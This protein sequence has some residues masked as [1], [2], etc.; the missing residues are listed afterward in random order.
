MTKT[1]KENYN[2]EFFN[3]NELHTRICTVI[4]NNED[5][6]ILS[7]R[8][9]EGQII[10][11]PGIKYFPKDCQMEK[12][13][14]FEMKISDFNGE[15]LNPDTKIKIFK[16]KVLHEDVE[17]CE[18]FYK[19]IS[20]TNFD[21][22]S[23]KYK[24]YKDM[25]RFKKE[26]KLKSEECLKIKIMNSDIKIHDVK[27]NLGMY[28]VNDILTKNSIKN[29]FSVNEYDNLIKHLISNKYKRTQMCLDETSEVVTL[30]SLHEKCTGDVVSIKCPSRHLITLLGKNNLSVNDDINLSIKIRIFLADNNNEEISSDTR[31]GIIK[32][33]VDGGVVNIDNILYKD[34]SITAFQK[35]LPHKIKSDKEWYSLNEGLYLRSTESLKF[36]V[37]NS[38]KNIDYKHTKFTMDIDL[39]ENTKL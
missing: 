6:V 16:N 14:R 37:V 9:P 10:R 30:K 1:Y 22:S 39:W 27:F 38:D 12:V 31:I 7:V 34:I 35:E 23:N 4:Y 32:E 11:I 21:E 26:I 17:L 28:L 29:N 13:P 18:L 24:L 15:E 25:F 19:D 8:C 5:D 20:I 33:K 2:V 3:L 36:Y